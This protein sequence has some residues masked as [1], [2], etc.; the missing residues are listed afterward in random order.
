MILNKLSRITPYDST[1]PT[2]ERTYAKLMIYSS[3]VTPDLITQQLQ[4]TPSKSRTKG[5]KWIAKKTGH[6]VEVKINSWFLSSEKQI[7][8]NDVR[9][10]LDWLLGNLQVASD[11]LIELQS[12][13]DIKMTVN[14]IW[15][16]AEGQGGPT[17]WPEQMEKMAKL[18]LECTFDV[19][20]FG[21]DDE[22]RLTIPKKL[23]IS[24]EN[25]IPRLISHFP[26]L[27]NIVDFEE[28]PYTLLNNFAFNL[29]NSIGS[30]TLSPDELEQA[31]EIMN[32][33]GETPD[34]KAKNL[35]VTG[36]LEIL[37]ENRQAVEIAKQ[38]LTGE[39]LF[40]LQNVL[41]E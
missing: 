41:S 14:C 35:L 16:S 33:M 23:P 2:C 7:I 27:F 34:S 1:Y 32:A 25:V 3:T 37:K 36:I 40:L 10:H 4:I 29:S 9:E 26:T 19:S 31:F 17:I 38:K 22:P 5:T 39:S 15:W 28:N 21:N 30:G 12:W 20:F 8:S 24:H 11:K 6:E 18:N 13:P